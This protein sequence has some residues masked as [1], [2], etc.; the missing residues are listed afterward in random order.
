MISPNCLPL[1][2]S[3]PSQPPSLSAF[4]LPPCLPLG[5]SSPPSYSLLLPPTPSY[6]L[7]LP[8]TPSYSLP[9]PPSPCCSPSHSPR[10]PFASCLPLHFPSPGLPAPLPRSLFACKNASLRPCRR[11][12]GDCGSSNRRTR[13]WRRRLFHNVESRSG[14]ERDGAPAPAP[15][16]SPHRLALSSLPETNFHVVPGESARPNPANSRGCAQPGSASQWRAGDRAGQVG[17][18]VA[19]PGTAAARAQEAKET[20]AGLLI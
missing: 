11:H 2:P 4:H 18:E 17:T 7:L 9:V 1:P 13:G 8:L 12:G 15:F 6:T 16:L 19:Q 3:P 14:A 20:V 10:T 5:P